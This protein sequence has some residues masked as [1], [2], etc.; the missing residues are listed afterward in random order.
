MVASTVLSFL[1]GILFGLS[2][3]APPGPMN[4]IIA[5][6]SVVRGWLAG[7]ISGTG[8]MTADIVFFLHAFAG[9]AT[10]VEQWPALRGT[11]ITLGGLLMLYFAYDAVN[12]A[13]STLTGDGVPG[14]SRG[15]EKA[16]VLGLTNPFQILFWL[17]VG[18]ALLE[19]GTIDILSHM[20]YVG[21]AAEGLLIVETGS[22]AL[23]AGFFG[24]IVVW[25]TGFPALLVVT[26]RRVDSLA[27]VVAGASALILVGFGFLFLWDGLGTLL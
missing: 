1:A 17:T 16:L 18:V 26:D 6:E 9:V 24:G 5:E 22:V 23:L 10:V 7:V 25:I 14:D 2:L 13:Q 12:S 11:M 20:P 27:P 15:F 4:A 19:P 21:D 3:A 8:A